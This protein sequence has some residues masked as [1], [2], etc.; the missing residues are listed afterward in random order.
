MEKIGKAISLQ[1]VLETTPAESKA[2]TKVIS[3][4][5]HHDEEQG[6][7][8][9]VDNAHVFESP[10]EDRAE[11]EEELYNLTKKMK[12]AK[13]G[14]QE[15]SPSNSQQGKSAAK[16]EDE[17]GTQDSHDG[18]F[19]TN[20]ER[21]VTRARLGERL[22][23][24]ET[25]ETF[26]QAKRFLAERHLSAWQFIKTSLVY[27]VLPFLGLAS[28]LHHSVG[29]PKDPDK[30][31]SSWWVLVVLV[32]QPLVLGLAKLT[33][34]FVVDLCCV[35][36]K[37]S[38]RLFGP[39]LTLTLMQ[40]KGWPFQL[41]CWGMWDLF[42]LYGDNAFVRHWAY[43]QDLF[44]VFTREN[45]AGH[46]TEAEVWLRILICAILGGGLVAMKRVSLGLWYSRAVYRRYGQDLSRLLQRAVLI[47]DLAATDTSG[48]S[49]S[50]TSFDTAIFREAS[51]EE[52]KGGHTE[53]EDESVDEVSTNLLVDPGKRSFYT[54]GLSLSQKLKIHK[55][56]GEWEEPISEEKKAGE[57][58]PIRAVVQFQAAFSC[59]DR[60][61]PF[62]ASFGLADKRENCIIS[63]Q[64]LFSRLTKTEENKDVIRFETIAALAVGADSNLDRAK[65]TL[66]VH[67]FR[68]ARNGELTL[69][70]R[71]I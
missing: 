56:L 16:G 28:L 5:E 11:I 9:D 70:P 42:L 7:L 8:V 1:T 25:R 30:A 32:W 48:I 71:S 37:I 59:I 65:L 34:A 27:W 51:I 67:I 69:L 57:H 29:N 49:L 64:R 17:P 2:E 26:E 23:A 47:S 54:G 33:E 58:V 22:V 44:E 39:L 66:L 68:P 36:T 45:Q 15:S 31:S 52:E 63:A 6:D 20:A 24:G 62:T 55:L 50:A 18:F 38:M 19:T 14:L 40:S 41:T 60:E 12:K 4:I 13:S 21:L 61:Y 43:S 53:P 46:V 3:S 35:H 10:V